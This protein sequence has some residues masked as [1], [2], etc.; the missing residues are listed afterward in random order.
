MPRITI[1]RFLSGKTTNIKKRLAEE[2]HPSRADLDFERAA[3]LRDQIQALTHIQ[4]NQGINPKALKDADLF[5]LAS[6][7]SQVCIQ[8]FFFRCN[9]RLVVK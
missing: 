5:A 2:M 9:G 6:Q 4:G 1:K 7:G 8:V 3:V